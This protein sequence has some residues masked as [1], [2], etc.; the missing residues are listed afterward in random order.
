MLD[1]S[2]D[3]GAGRRR[4]RGRDAQSASRCSTPAR[5]CTSSRRS[6]PRSLRPRSRQRAASDH[7]ARGTPN[8][9][10]RRAVRR[11][12]D[13]RL[14]GQRSRSLREARAAQ[15]GSSTSP[16]MPERGNFVTPAMHRAGDLVVAVTAGGVPGAA[17][18]IRDAIA[19]PSTTAMPRAVRELAALRR[20]VLDRG[21][22]RRVA[23]AAAATAS[24]TDFCDRVESGA[25]RRRGCAEW[26]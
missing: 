20:D 10:R 22:A 25:L 23:R 21:D 1:G 12:R 18:R 2:G 5:R 6:T 14:R 17:A 4:R 13:R 8:R 15:V 11:R 19:A 24:A 9:H 7:R 26:R 16:T 3:L